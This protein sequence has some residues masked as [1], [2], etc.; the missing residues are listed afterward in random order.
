MTNR[1]KEIV[2]HLSEDDLNRFLT[3]TDEEKMSKRLI[4]IKRLYKGA[5]LKD[6]SD[7]V[8]KSQSTENLWA[9]RW[10]EGGLGKL[11]PNF[12]GGR[13]PKLGDD[14][15]KRLI[16]RLEEGETQNKQEIQHLLN[17]GYDVKFH[18]NYL[19][20]FLSD[21]GLSYA[22]LRTERPNQ[23]DNADEILENA[24]PT[25]S[26]RMRQTIHTT[27]DLTT[28]V[29]RNGR[30]TRMSGWTMEQRSDSSIFRTHNHRTIHNDSTR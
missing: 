19:P 4:F 27:N 5:T 7:D 8:G 13:P 26:T 28:T 17:T 3:Q 21:L 24:L 29:K 10:N 12:G 14:E 20:R 16:E 2:R 1:E 11:T 18:P 15:R 30:L 25:H 23:P 22:I 6:A 9:K